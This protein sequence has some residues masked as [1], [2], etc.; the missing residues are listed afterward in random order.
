MTNFDPSKVILR[1]D[2]F[3]AMGNDGEATATVTIPGSVSI[4]AASRY[5][6]TA[7]V[8]VGV[9]GSMADVR[10]QSSK[11]GSQYYLAG[12]QISFTRTGSLGAYS[13]YA[14]AYHL[15]GDTMRVQAYAVNPYGS[16]MT[17]ASGDETF[18]FIIR[19]YKTPFN[20]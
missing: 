4:A 9:S 2:A 7:D 5:L 19:T 15:D 18:T 12:V 8:D 10:F 14:D 16:T 6:I 11:A 17:G 1:T 13:V 3:D 20:T